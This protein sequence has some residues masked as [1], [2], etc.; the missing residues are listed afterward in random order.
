MYFIWGGVGG[1]GCPSRGQYPRAAK[2]HL[3]PPPKPPLFFKFGS[4]GGLSRISD[5]R[6]PPPPLGGVLAREPPDAWGRRHTGPLS[7]VWAVI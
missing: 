4:G 2:T 1:P 7:P 6:E 3:K 5:F